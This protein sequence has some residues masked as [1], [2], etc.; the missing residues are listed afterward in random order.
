MRT[1]STARL[2]NQRWIGLAGLCLVALLCVPRIGFAGQI[3]LDFNGPETSWEVRCI[4][5]EVRL[6]TQERRRDGARQGQ[7]EFVRVRSA[8]E[9]SPMRLEQAI[10]PIRVLDELTASLWFKADRPG[11]TLAIRVAFRDA[12]DPKTGTQLSLMILGDTYEQSGKWQQLRARTTEKSVEDQLRK[13]RARKKVKL[14]PATMYVDRIVI[15]WQLVAGDS[16]ILIDDLEVGPAV[17]VD[18]ASTKPNIEQMSGLADQPGAATDSRARELVP[19]EF[20]LNK[21]QVEGRPY[22]VRMA[23]HHGERPDVVAD[24]GIN[25]LWVPELESI[26]NTGQFRDRGIWLTATPPY[27][28]RADGEP[29]ESDDASLLPFGQST[30]PVLFWT[31]G[32][33]MTSDAKPRLQRWTDQVRDADR[34]FKRPLAGD[35]TDDELVAS[36]HLNLLGLSRHVLNSGVTLADYRDELIR[37]RNIALPGTYTFTWIQTEPA[38]ELMEIKHAAD[39][40]PIVEPEQLT[41]QVYAALAAGCRGIGFWSTTPLDSTG[42]G[43][44]ERQLMIQQL[45]LELGLL[46]GWLATSSS[47]QLIPFTVELP[48]SKSA[49]KSAELDQRRERELSAALIRSDF[50]YLLLPMWLEENSQFVPAQLAASTATVI[51]PVGG[52]TATAWRITTTGRVQNLSRET[53]AGGIRIVLPNFDQTAAILI[54]SDPGVVDQINQ[55]IANIQDRSAT[56]MVE[57]CRLKLER[58]RK[59][60][61]QLQALGVGQPDAYELLRKAKLQFDMA[62]ARLKQQEYHTARQYADVSLRYVR[63]LQRA[64]WDHAVA[65]LP[66]PVSSSYALCFQTLP[67]HWRLIKGVEKLGKSSEPNKLPSGD[68]EDVDTLIAAGWKHD[69]H[70]TANV[71]SSAELHPVA[72]QGKSSLRLAAEPTIKEPHTFQFQFP[73]VAVT[74][75][76]VSVHAGQ[77]VKITG[78]VKTPYPIVRSLDGAMIYDSLLGKTGALRIVN[79]PDWQRFEMWRVVPE[80]QPVT[81][82]TELHGLGE[83]LLDDLRITAVT[84]PHEVAEAPRHIDPEVKPSRFS[85]LDIRRLNPL[86]DRK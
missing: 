53:V 26:T 43:A 47:V 8:V 69:Q 2:R 79:S 23:N 72:R 52:E 51:V 61:Q 27:A 73:P 86:R 84:L 33:R 55:R 82:T 12:I 38:P 41:A 20:R 81:V 24:A 35:V 22:F 17:P 58:V 83:L 15:G 1:V 45:N 65:R 46:E 48:K 40:T 78:W 21:L 49:R 57:L 13:L 31:L 60:D 30:S 44:R 16:E 64:H 32:V 14:D 70:P 18:L 59:V 50:G 36:R 3:E 85:P 75:P 71:Q 4:Q 62:E 34:A 68:F 39:E 19:V 25:T 29:L 77:L 28:K 67:A 9:T 7:A 74:S 5:R 66:T 54:T 42:P 11:A 63:I 56:A 10:S 6:E 80:S 37:R 76:P